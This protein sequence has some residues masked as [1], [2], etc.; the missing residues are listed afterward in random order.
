VERSIIRLPSASSSVGLVMLLI[1]ACGGRVSGSDTGPGR[2]LDDFTGNPAM[3]PSGAIAPGMPASGPPDPS[4]VP[5]SKPPNVPPAAP[6]G[7]EIDASPAA[8][9][10]AAAVVDATTVGVDSGFH[11]PDGGP[12]RVIP[13][14]DNVSVD[15]DWAK[16]P[17]G[18]SV[19]FNAPTF[20]EGRA[21]GG[22]TTGKIARPS[23]LA[24]FDVDTHVETPVASGLD[25]QSGLI[26]DAKGNI[27]FG[28]VGGSPWTGVLHWLG[29]T[30]ETTSF[31]T[32]VDTAGGYT[33]ASRLELAASGG[34][35]VLYIDPKLVDAHGDVLRAAAI[36]KLNPNNGRGAT[37]L[38]GLD[39]PTGLA[40]DPLG[41]V[42]YGNADYGPFRITLMRYEPGHDPTSLGVVIDTTGGVT[43]YAFFDIVISPAFELY[44]TEQAVYPFN[45][46]NTPLRY[47]GIHKINLKTG[48]RST[49]VP[50]LEQPMGLALDAAGNLYFG[51]DARTVPMKVSLR[52][53]SPA[54]EI[55]DLG[56]LIDTSGYWVNCTLLN[57]A[58]F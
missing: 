52:R 25:C 53:L 12:F 9:D 40:L 26:V 23:G 33:T 41:V 15:K 32:I 17:R 30:G 55:A 36:R 29:P 45:D 47:G 16:V 14:V 19:L 8:S 54:G 24:R 51:V 3:P 13:L 31:G 2:R 37:V 21:D 11:V 34:G 28:N 20:S 39:A 49:V 7:V 57:L 22:H 5:P 48:E 50:N 46:L 10:S 43:D 18:K 42:Y 35:E 38:D 56:T 27:F 1:C 44:Y 58:T 4:V 6:P